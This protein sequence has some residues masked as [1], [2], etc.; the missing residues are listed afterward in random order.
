MNNPTFKAIILFSWIF[1]TVSFYNQ[2]YGQDKTDIQRFELAMIAFNEG[3]YEE[4]HELFSNF[5][6]ISQNHEYLAA[7]YY[8]E[9]LSSFK[10][11]KWVNASEEFR[12]FM[13]KFPDHSLRNYARYY[14]ASSDYYI[15]DFYNSAVQFS[16]LLSPKTTFRDNITISLERLLWGYLNPEE[17]NVLKRR[18]SGEPAEEIIHFYAIKHLYNQ[19]KLALLL[20]EINK[21]NQKFPESKYQ[22]NLQSFSKGAEQRLTR[23]LSIVAVLPLSGTYQEYGERIL[24]GMKIGQAD[25]QSSFD[26]ELRIIE[27]DSQ[28][29]PLVAVEEVK[30]LLESET[31][32]AIV[33]P[34]LSETAVPLAILADQ[35]RVPMITPTA[36]RDNLST[37]SP[38][39]F[40]LAIT[41]EYCGKILAR[42][43]VDSLK[44]SLFAILAPDDKYGHSMATA[45]KNALENSG[46]KAMDIRFYGEDKID[47]TIDFIEIKEPLLKKMDLL[48]AEADTTDSTFYDEYGKL[49]PR[50]E[51]EVKLDAL[52]LP[53]YSSELSLILPQIPF[54]YIKTQILGANG[55]NLEEVKK[56]GRVY[57]D[58][59]IFIPDDFYVDESS[60]IWFGFARKYN[61]KYDEKPDKF[62]ALGYDA[63]GILGKAISNGAFYPEVVRDYLSGI[64]NYQGASQNITFDPTG[65]NTQATILKFNRDHF[66]RIQ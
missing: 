12:E 3:A 7:S 50:H 38:F 49:K 55:W 16:T 25:Y 43:A 29:D 39:V 13:A 59:A 24:R 40:Q 54:N 52:F 17:I 66:V 6:Q 22:K 8:M 37:I 36:S 20:E 63:L 31:P 34:L 53:A 60:K 19:G 35:Y 30:K 33:G 47:F 11:Q 32:V 10:A 26:Q 45:F 1:L 57:A 27:L 4:A 41:P 56:I 62:A 44:D 14:I 23:Q 9:A 42:F 18:F 28:G 46:I 58:S 61:T 65:A 51:W 21:F 64:K 15:G 2:L 48:V 5:N